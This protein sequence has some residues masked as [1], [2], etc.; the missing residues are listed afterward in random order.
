MLLILIELCVFLIPVVIILE[1]DYITQLN[2]F[3]DF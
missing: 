1:N 3:K 2:I